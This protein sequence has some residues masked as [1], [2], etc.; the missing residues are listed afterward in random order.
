MLSENLQREA[1]LLQHSWDRHTPEHLDEYLITATEDP[2]INIPSILTRALFADT[3]FPDQF[4][5]LCDEELRFGLCLTWLTDAL[6]SHPRSE[7]AATSP[8]FPDAPPFLTETAQ[9]LQDPAFPLIDYLT[10]ALALEPDI[11]TNDTFASSVL[12]T[13]A[14]VWQA[15]L[16]EHKHTLPASPK[17]RVIELAC[18]SGNDYRF[19]HNFGFAP[20]LDYTGID[21]AGKNTANA[22]RRFP[23]IDFRTANAFATGLPDASADII[24]AHDLYE[25]LSLEALE[26]ALAETA[27]LLRPG[28][29]AWLHF[30]NLADT[31]QHEARPHESYHWNLLSQ[32][33]ILETLASHNLTCDALPIRDLIHEK[34]AFPGYYN[35]EAVLITA[36]KMR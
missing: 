8:E 4:A 18:G 2:R 6:E 10:E 7:L 20:L 31:T 26:A 14:N 22:K 5:A 19:L 17:P 35:Q 25:H 36:E 1:Q 33:R 12:D 34:F 15:E 32:S 16:P 21:I 29:Q 9:L 13:F 23:Q 24:F 3:L 11:G 28:G 30:F 27:R